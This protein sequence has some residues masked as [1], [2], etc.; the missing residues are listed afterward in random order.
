MYRMQRE[1]AGSWRLVFVLASAGI[2]SLLFS[3][4]C[5]IWTDFGLLAWIGL[6]RSYLFLYPDK[7]ENRGYYGTVDGVFYF[8]LDQFLAGNLQPGNLSRWLFLQGA[9]YGICSWY[10]SLLI[11]KGIPGISM[12]NDGCALDDL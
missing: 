4:F 10:F 5:G 7:L 8:D 11:E 9:L 1:E 2:T 12:H 3:F 6:F